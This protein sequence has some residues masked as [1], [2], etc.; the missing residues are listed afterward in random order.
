MEEE[1]Q[2]FYKKNS[3][4]LQ[5][6]EEFVIGEEYFNRDGQGFCYEGKGKFEFRR[7]SPL[8][9][10]ERLSELGTGKFCTKEY[11]KQ[12]INLFWILSNQLG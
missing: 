12:L 9:N 4:P 1:L 3:N 6:V 5:K 11:K 10:G 8:I 2:I 7:A